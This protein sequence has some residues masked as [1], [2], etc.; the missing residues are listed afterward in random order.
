M[1]LYLHSVQTGPHWDWVEEVREVHEAEAEGEG[2]EK[3]EEGKEAAVE[4]AVEVV[5]NY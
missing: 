5:A 1:F 4:E 2:R 3:G